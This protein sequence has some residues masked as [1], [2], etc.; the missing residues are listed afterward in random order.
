MR[1][2]FLTGWNFRRIMYTLIGGFIVVYSLIQ[3]DWFIAVL[4]GYFT[5]MGIFG[6]GCAGGS[7]YTRNDYSEANK[8]LKME[9][10]TFDEIK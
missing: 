2:R 10:A 9:D 8:P 7:C 4:G 6:F 5:A 3:H 1:E